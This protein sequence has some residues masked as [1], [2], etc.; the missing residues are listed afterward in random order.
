MILHST[1][2]IFI[3]TETTFVPVTQYGNWN[4]I[5]QNPIQINL[6]NLALVTQNKKKKKKKKKK[7]RNCKK[8]GGKK[9][10]ACK[11]YL[12]LLVF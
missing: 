9:G 10:T 6:Y 11:V 1:H 8:K 2:T 12:D 7:K 3:I 5:I 4:I